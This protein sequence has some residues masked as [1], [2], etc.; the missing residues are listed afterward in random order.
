MKRLLSLVASALVGAGAGFSFAAE[1]GAVNLVDCPKCEKRIRISDD[2]REVF[3]NLSRID[4]ARQD[5]MVRRARRLLALGAPVTPAD[6]ATPLMG[7]SSWNTFAVDISEPVILGVARAMATNGLKRAGYAYVNIDDGFFGG[8]AA[9]GRLLFHPTR[10]PNGMKGTVDG[11]HALGLKAGTYS[12]AGANTC[13]SEWSGDKLGVGSGLYGHDAADCALHFRE[14]GFDFFKVDY[15]GGKT[16]KLDERTRYTEIARAI[17]ATGAKGVRL[18][19]CRWAFP[20]TWA[21]DIAGSWRT[22]KDIRASWESVRDILAENLYLSAYARPGHFNDMDMLEVGQRKGGNVTSAFIAHGDTGLT[23]DEEVT[24]FGMWCL[25]SSPLVL[26]CDVRNMLPE[27]LKLVTNPYLV[28]MNQSPLG[29][30]AYVVQREGEAYV[31]VKDADE[32]FGTARYVGLYNAEDREREFRVRAGTL[33]LGGRMALFDLVERA[34]IGEVSGEL[35]VKVRPHAARFFRIDADRRLERTVYEAETAFL[36]DYS[37]LD[38]TTYGSEKGNV[39]RGRAFYAQ[40]PGASGG[41]AAV[42]LGKRA[43]NDLVWKEVLIAAGGPRRLR[44]RCRPVAGNSFLLQ[45][46]G[47]TPRRLEARKSGEAFSE[48]TAD[49][50][51]SAGTHAVRLFNPEAAMPEIDVMTVEPSPDVAVRPGEEW[52]FDWSWREVR[53]PSFAYIHPTVTAYD[54]AGKVVYSES[55]GQLQ[56]RTFGPEDM[57]VQRWR[58]YARVADGA[59]AGIPANYAVSID[60]I[61]LPNTARRVRLSVAREGDPAEIADIVCRPTRLEKPLPAQVDGF[62][63]IREDPKDV[64]SDAALDAILAKRE[65]CVPRL[66]SDGDRTDLYVNGRRIVPRIYKTAAFAVPNRHPSVTAMS[67]KGF[68]IFTVGVNLAPCARPFAESATG[69]WRADGS[70]DT[71]KVRRELRE[72]L[73]RF[74]D[75]LFMLVFIIQ[76]HLGWAERH[77]TEILKNDKGQYGFVKGVYRV[78]DYRDTL[79]YDWKEDEFPAF[80]YASV[81]FARDVAAVME[82]IFSDL[83]TWPEGKAVIG[84]YLN[85]GTDTQWLDAFDNDLSGQQAADCSDVARKRFSDYCRRKYGR[86]SETAIP[87]PEAFW[88]DDRCH[89]SEHA[90][91]AM[92]DYREFLARA[93]TQTKLTI[94][95]GVKRGS[96]GR[97]LVGSYSPNGGMAGYPLIC[98]SFVRKLIE[99]PDWDFFAVVPDYVREHA[100]PVLSAVFDGSLVRHGKLFVSE[101]DLRSHDVGN[102]GSWGSSF[103]REHHTDETFRR[104]TL[105]FVVN[106]LTH[107]GAYHAYDMDGGMYATAAAQETWR[108]ANAVAEHAKY[109]K[110]PA[111]SIALVCGERYWD[112]QSLARER[113]LAYH[114][115]EHPKDALSR[116]GAPWNAYLVDDL[117]ADEKAE[118]PG[119][120]YFSDLTTVTYAQFAELRRRFARDGRVVVWSYRPGLFAADGA[121][122]E[123][124]LG[125]KPAPEDLQKLGFADGRCADPL[126]SGVRGTLMSAFATWGF[127]YPRLCRPDP[128]AGWKTLANFRDTDIPALAVRRTD[129]CT[130]VYTSMPGGVTPELLRNLLREADLQ[131]LMETNELSGYGSGLFYFV[132]QSDGEKRFRLP[133]GRV[134]GP[135]LAGPAFSEAGDGTCSVTMRRGDIFILE[136]KGE[137]PATGIG[138]HQGDYATCPDD[139]AESLKLAAEKGCQF[140]EF[141]VQR[142]KTGEFVVLHDHELEK[143]TD[144]KG[145]VWQKPFDYV[146][147]GHIIWRDRHYPDMRI[148]TLEEALAVLPRENFLINLHCYGMEGDHVARDVAIRVRELGRLDQCYIA[149]ILPEIEIARAAVPELQTC[150]MTRP[151]GV[152]YYRPW[153]DEK[154]AEYLR[155]TIENK[156]QYL[157]LRQPWP[158]KFSDEAHAHGIKVNL[159]TCDPLC[160]DP[161]YLEHILK[162]LA[163]DYVLTENLEPMLKRF[164]ELQDE[165]RRATRKSPIVRP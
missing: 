159:C 149:A 124:S 34:D 38:E 77:P 14:L 25:M 66:V 41:V 122:I 45:I 153:S 57:S 109:E 82:K 85:A 13:G 145:Y 18:N 127:S 90:P 108:V 24:H 27:T 22:T 26:G 148:S 101:L 78:T 15:C 105:Y 141:D 10:F 160:N 147:S 9:D 55:V 61:E 142:C 132:A 128:S 110:R 36:T 93:T 88:T 46:D 8:R 91:T 42:N 12:D 112:F 139:T 144:L 67:K 39:E 136:T 50:V 86:T 16:L 94:A 131:P 137:L 32:R 75:G 4:P 133:K 74:P 116:T 120:V 157:Q 63:E 89:Y 30:Q 155:T 140:V 150:N 138:G 115:R 135:V 62:P 151:E 23:V 80:S 83:E 3:V 163:I 65:K 68:N 98:Q 143:K 54:E 21:A 33:D 119:V 161:Q 102:W 6:P 59:D 35:R 114:L 5:E 134:P 130:E 19:V 111:E 69:I 11:I 117:L 73:R 129:A 103:W 71:E 164:R 37:E 79:A 97:I 158:R 152:D 56:Q 165:D 17:A 52:Q 84:T 87:P 60:K 162:D 81:T 49:V 118:L 146:R 100:D 64:L 92:S 53:M 126:M 40:R 123:K 1:P 44:F 99:S 51:L 125:L 106:A 70:V 156:C 95:Q 96:K 58:V 47:G 28:A 43:T 29:Q 2:G 107:G 113:T 104:K 72:N 7:W 20:G 121:K 154:N 76:P 48:V 31:L